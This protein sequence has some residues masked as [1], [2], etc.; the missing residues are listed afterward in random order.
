MINQKTLFQIIE[1]S[2]ELKEGDVNLESSSS[3]I[4]NWDSLGH[5]SILV[6][7]DKETSGKA[8]NISELA[9]AQ[10]VQ[11]IFDVLKKNKLAE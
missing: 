7:I 6:A 4:N 1:N 11:T 8:A 5:L 9:S 2:L 3:N 10:T